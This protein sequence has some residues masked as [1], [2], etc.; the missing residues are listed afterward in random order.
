LYF[1][2]EERSVFRSHRTVLAEASRNLSFCISALRDFSRLASVDPRVWRIVMAKREQVSV[3][4]PPELRAFAERAAAS[5]DRPLAPWI[6][7]LVAAE[8]ARNAA[9][10]QRI[11][12]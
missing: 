7:R 6:R 11:T 4:F 2:G 1:Y 10:E 3:P 9:G 12:T 8:A 5:E